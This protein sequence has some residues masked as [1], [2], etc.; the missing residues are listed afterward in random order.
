M[1]GVCCVLVRVREIQPQVCLSDSRNHKKDIKCFPI[2]YSKV[3]QA[4]L[5]ELKE[6]FLTMRLIF[7]PSSLTDSLMEVLLC[8]VNDVGGIYISLFASVTYRVN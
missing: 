6:W 4:R 3:K 8:Y 1:H 7:F 2:R 5:S